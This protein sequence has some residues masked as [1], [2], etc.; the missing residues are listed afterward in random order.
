[1]NISEKLRN[2]EKELGRLSPV[3]K[4][5]LGTDGSVTKL[6]EVITG[7]PVGITTRVQ[8]IIDADNRIAEE[9]QIDPGDP[10]NYRVVELKNNDTAEVLVYAVSYTPVNRLDPEVK[11]DFMLADIPIGKIMQKH[12][13]ETRREIT[14][15]GVL[16]A[17][18][19]FSR[20][21]GIF[22]DEALL[23]RDYRII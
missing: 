12:K 14:D 2:I 3:Q 1:M 17:D 5:L 15:A 4:I 16:K 8:E 21:F 7:S 18:T 19:I 9:L 23:S 11:A 20:T 13:M 22:K 6:L 10:V